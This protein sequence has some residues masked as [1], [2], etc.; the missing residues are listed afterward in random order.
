MLNYEKNDEECD[1]TGD[2]SS[3][4]AGPLINIL[5]DL[6]TKKQSPFN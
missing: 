3:N 1:A 2:D 4:V 6:M 5:N